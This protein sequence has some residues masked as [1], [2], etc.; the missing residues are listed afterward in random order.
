MACWLPRGGVCSRK[1]SRPE[2]RDGCPLLYGCCGVSAAVDVTGRLHVLYR[3]AW[4]GD[5]RAKYLLRGDARALVSSLTRFLNAGASRRVRCR[6]RRPHRRR[7]E[8]RRGGNAGHVVWTRVSDA[9]PSPLRLMHPPGPGDH[10]KHPALAVA[11]DG[12]CCSC[13]PRAWAGTVVSGAD[14]FT[15]FCRRC[16]PRTAAAP[17]THGTAHPHRHT[18]PAPAR[19][20]ERSD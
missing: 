19:A 10:R 13:E 16:R 8:S 9:E 12:A 15:V 17:F 5:G 14:E 4:R 11:P 20:G 7:M 3:G 1:H 2:R 6:R 18:R